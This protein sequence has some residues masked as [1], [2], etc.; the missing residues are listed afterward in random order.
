MATK[1]HVS[2]YGISEVGDY[3]GPKGGPYIENPWGMTT[4]EGAR[5]TLGTNTIKQYSGQSPAA[6]DSFVQTVDGQLVVGLLSGTLDNLRKLKGLPTT[7]LVGHLDG[8][9]GDPLADPVVPPVPGTEEVL[10]VQAHLLATEEQ[11]LYVRTT[12]PEGPRTY[13]IPRT[14]VANLPELNLGRTGYLEPTATFD[15]YVDPTIGDLYFVE[16]AI[17]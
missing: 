12:G 16:D 4:Q 9:P 7:T 6:L 1:R 11:S 14:K 13:R 5:I 2:L 15:I 8:S 3:T 10:S 17:A